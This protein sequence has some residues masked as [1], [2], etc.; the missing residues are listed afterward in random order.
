MVKKNC[1]IAHTFYVSKSTLAPHNVVDQDILHQA[2]KNNP[3]LE[4]TGCLFRAPNTYA[5]IL[6]GPIQSI[7]QIMSVIRV[8]AR[9]YDL[10][11]WPPT[12]TKTRFFQEWSM[13]YANKDIADAQLSAFGQA[14][15]RQISEIANVLRRVFETEYG[16]I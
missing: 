12:E 13:G 9:H 6:E 1:M 3:R 8:D 10:I 11:E 2:R 4:L 7:E 16:M 5:Q 15:P 14:K